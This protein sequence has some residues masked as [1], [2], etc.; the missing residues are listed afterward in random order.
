MYED[1]SNQQIL[2]FTAG[3]TLTLG[4]FSEPF[5][6]YT[7]LSIFSGA[8]L[9][10][11]ESPFAFDQVVDLATLGLGLPQQIAGPLVL[12]TGFKFNIDGGSSYYGRVIDSNVEFRWQRR[13]YDLGVFYN[14]SRGVGGISFHLNDFSFNGTGIP[15]VPYE[16]SRLNVDNLANPW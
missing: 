3:P 6:D 16:P 10:K 7:K 5:L 1:G 4:N 2:S 15:F 14:P 8:S 11:G 13:S 12:N 9:K